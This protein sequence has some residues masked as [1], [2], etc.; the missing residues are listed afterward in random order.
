MTALASPM[1]GPEVRGVLDKAVHAFLQTFP[2]GFDDPAYHKQETSY[3]RAAS[4]LMQTTLGKD[5]FGELLMA[6]KYDEIAQ[7]IKA[8][9]KAC[10]KAGGWRPLDTIKKY[11]EASPKNRETFAQELFRVLYGVDGTE[12]ERFERFTDFVYSINARSWIAATIF[13][14]FALPQKYTVVKPEE[15]KHLLEL[16][17]YGMSYR[18]YPSWQ[19]YCAFNEISLG[20]LD[21]LQQS[22]L[23]NPAPKDMIDAQSFLWA[24]CSPHYRIYDKLMA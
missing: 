9:R 11:L 17:P 12:G 21:F 5:A 16:V 10:G 6:E 24:C 2:K 14:F 3:K 20:V 15:A 1:F 7:R 19:L 18:P 23:L 8:V 13:L 22:P 4:H